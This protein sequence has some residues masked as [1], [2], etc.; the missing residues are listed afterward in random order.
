MGLQEFWHEL[1]GSRLSGWFKSKKKLPENICSII[2][3]RQGSSTR[4]WSLWHLV[5]G[6]ETNFQLLKQASHLQH[7]HDAEIFSFTV[8]ILASLL[9]TPSSIKSENQNKLTCLEF[10]TATTKPLPLGKINLFQ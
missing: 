8:N 5:S 4:E 6:L 1:L 3:R 10:I 7:S 9:E 2:L